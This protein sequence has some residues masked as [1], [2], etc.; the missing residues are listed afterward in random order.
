MSETTTSL[1]TP[2]YLT[3]AWTLDDNSHSRTIIGSNGGYESTVYQISTKDTT[4]APCE[5]CLKWCSAYSTFQVQYRSRKRYSP[6]HS[7]AVYGTTGEQWTDWGDWAG[8]TITGTETATAATR[9]G[10]N[11]WAMNST[12]PFA[13]SNNFATYDAIEWQ[14]RVRVYD[15]A[16]GKCSLWATQTLRQDFTPSVNMYAKQ[17]LAG[18]VTVTYE[19]N[20]TRGGKVTVYGNSWGNTPLVTKD[21]ETTGTTSTITLQI[22]RKNITGLTAGSNRLYAHSWWFAPAC[23]RLGSLDVLDARKN[24]VTMTAHPNPSTVT[25]PVIS[26]DGDTLQITD[27]SYTSVFAYIEW[28]DEEGRG[29]ASEVTLTKNSGKW[30][31]D[32]IAPP[33]DTELTIRAVAVGSDGV[34]WAQSS[35]T[36]TIDSQKRLSWTLDDG[37][38]VNVT[39]HTD[40]AEISLSETPEGETV[41]PAGRARPLSRY[42]TGGTRTISCSAAIMRGSYFAD[43]AKHN[44]ATHKELLAVLRSQSD[45]WFRTPNGGRYR[46]RVTDFSITQNS[47]YEQISVS[48]EEVSNGLDG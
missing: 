45:M 2:A 12:A 46:V 26:L 8:A 38:G 4:S 27:V 13:T 5:I 7:Q 39:L 31:G 1:A 15:A 29:Y 25:P 28:E 48:M 36:A 6:A 43:N 35:I 40:A 3:W 34:L 14:T 11:K 41:K 9:I 23:S 30:A 47:N 19:T 17:E 10:S 16:N 21:Q 22:P 37:T 44:Q 18:Y 33:Y 24:G 32:L 42:G 20:W